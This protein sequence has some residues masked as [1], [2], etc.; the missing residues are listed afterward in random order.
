MESQKV[1]KKLQALENKEK[2][3]PRLFPDSEVAGR[4][5]DKLFRVRFKEKEQ[6]TWLL[7]HAE[8]QVSRVTEFALRMFICVYRILDRFRES[9]VCI[10]VIAEKDK[11]RWESALRQLEVA[12]LEYWSFPR[13]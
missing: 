6:P 3:L 10:G 12:Q 5:A 13:D 7:I 8:V 4:V 2:E 11:S 9:V 1:W